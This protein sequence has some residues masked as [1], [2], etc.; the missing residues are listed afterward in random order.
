MKFDFISDEST[1]INIEGDVGTFGWIQSH[2]YPNYI[3]LGSACL[4]TIRIPYGKSFERWLILV[5][6]SLLDQ[7]LA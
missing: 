4:W 2:N 3:D 6:K 7:N 1:I 5:Q